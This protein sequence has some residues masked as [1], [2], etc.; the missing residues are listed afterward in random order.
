ME[1]IVQATFDSKSWA[2]A[3]P[4]VCKREL[5][6]PNTLAYNASLATLCVIVKRSSGGDFAL[7]E[8]A[9]NYLLKGLDQR[10]R[11]DGSPVQHAIVV[12]ADV[13]SQQRIKPVKQWSAEEMRDRLS[14]VE[15]QL[16]KFGPYWWIKTSDFDD[17]P[18]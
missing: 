13:D 16:G 14:G 11:K 15:P 8:G 7:S 12:L 1:Q 5:I 3:S 6:F 2:Y 17:D 9:L 10:A 4:E 18:W